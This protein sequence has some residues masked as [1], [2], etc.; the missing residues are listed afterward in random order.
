MRSTALE[1][2]RRMVPIRGL[3]V[4]SY[5]FRVSENYR[6]YYEECIYAHAVA[7]LRIKSPFCSLLV[8]H[9]SAKSL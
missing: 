8:V 2:L 7:V 9:R 1:S 5:P 4:Y 3:T 6:V